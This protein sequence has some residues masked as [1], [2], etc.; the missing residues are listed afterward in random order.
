MRKYLT[1]YLKYIDDIL[2]QDSISQSAVDSLKEEHLRQIRFMQHERLV[3]FLVTFMFAIIL[4]ICIGIFCI[5]ENI[6]F[7]AL[8][9][10]ILALICPYTWHYY[11]LENSV[12]KMY[13]QY[14]R[15]CNLTNLRTDSE[16]PQKGSDLTGLR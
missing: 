3:H 5:T 14:N 8:I 16:I 9:L 10:L 6:A 2:K 7:M 13:R 4:F 1:A 11:F 12:Q 15:M